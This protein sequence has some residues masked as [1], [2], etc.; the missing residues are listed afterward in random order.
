MSVYTKFCTPSFV[1]RL[2]DCAD[3]VDLV[4]HCSAG[5][6]RSAAVAA[7]AADALIN[8]QAIRCRDDFSNVEVARVHIAGAIEHVF[9]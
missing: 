1:D 6:S 8:V 2:H 5:V 7:W 3:E 9:G 4:V